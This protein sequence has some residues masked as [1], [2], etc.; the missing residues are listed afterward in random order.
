MICAQGE[1]VDSS[2]K[3][4]KCVR[5][6]RAID[7]LKLGLAGLAIILFILAYLSALPPF[8]RAVDPVKGE[9]N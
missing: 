5:R 8:L 2:S 6:K 9:R 4:G 3:K 1:R 7:R